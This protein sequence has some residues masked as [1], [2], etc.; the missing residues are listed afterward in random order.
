MPAD[1]TWEQGRLLREFL[2]VVF[3]EVKLRL[4]C[5]CYS[6]SRRG[7]SR[8]RGM[9]RTMQGE[10]IGGGFEFRDGDEAN[11]FGGKG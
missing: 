9:G 5:T 11:L 3:T 6:A 7:G 2:G 10:D 4:W 1:G 8:G